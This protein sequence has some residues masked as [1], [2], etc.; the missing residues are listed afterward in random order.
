VSGLTEEFKCAQFLDDLPEVEFWGRN[1][2]R[3]NT[4]FRL[5][6]SSDWF[7]PDFLCQ[8]TDGRVMAVEYKGKHLYSAVDAEEKRAVGAVWASRS[9]GKCLF[10]MP[11]EGDFSQ[12]AR[13]VSRK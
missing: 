12:I 9:S 5:Q 10:A 7:Y 11:T 2:P 1:L 13:L 8:L 6:T 4:S 3:K